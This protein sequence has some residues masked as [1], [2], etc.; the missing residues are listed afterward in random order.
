MVTTLAEAVP[1][2]VLY[3]ANWLVAHNSQAL[4]FFG[5][6]WSLAIEE[7]FYLLWPLLL[8]VPAVRRR[9]TTVLPVFIVA[10]IVGRVVASHFLGTA[11]MSWTPF[12]SDELATG[13]LLAAW[14]HEGRRLPSWLTSWQVSAVAMLVMV[15]MIVPTLPGWISVDGATDIAAAATTVVIAHLVTRSRS[16][17]SVVLGWR[18]LVAVGRVSYGIYLYHYAILLW[19]FGR[20]WSTTHTIAVA[21]PF[22]TAL[23]VASWYLIERPAL[24]LKDRIGITHHGSYVEA[25]APNLN[26]SAV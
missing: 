22:T 20:G 13:A 26:E 1:A 15:V 24:A 17:V 10:M 11:V 23:V 2:V 14:L 21:W 19:L 6:T 5:Q 9:L 8:L 16:P 18:P 25:V 3:V 12:R 7:Q 4:G